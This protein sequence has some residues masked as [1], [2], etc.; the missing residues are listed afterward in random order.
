[1]AENKK[2]FI[3]YCDWK[4]TFDALPDAEAG[5]LVKH[6]FA[7]VNDEN[8]VS[9]NILINAVFANI[10]MQLK[11]DLRKYEAFIEKQ[12]DN[13]KRGGRPLK[14]EV[15]QKTQA[16]TEEPKKADNDIVTD[17]DNDNV[18]E[19]GSKN[20]NPPTPI[21]QNPVSTSNNSLLSYKD[22]YHEFVTAR[23]WQEKFCMD[24]HLEIDF[25][26]TDMKTFLAELDKSDQFPKKLS[27]TKFFYTKRL[28]KFLNNQRISEQLTRKKKANNPT[29]S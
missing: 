28:E 9:E 15:T 21:L 5:L 27:D 8:P 24:H 17:N 6:L 25:I 14:A 16:F 12:R 4:A 23:S 2:S 20:E 13:G 7:Y 29:I 11:R 19:G 18:S 3:A 1:M 10:K 22:T 26:L